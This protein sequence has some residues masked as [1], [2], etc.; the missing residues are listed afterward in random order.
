[1]NAS[2]PIPESFSDEESA[3][4]H[5]DEDPGLCRPQA[6]DLDPRA[7]PSGLDYVKS[8]IKEVRAIHKSDVRDEERKTQT[9]SCVY[10]A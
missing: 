5:L 6:L 8:Y 10:E 4:D 9:L 7:F 3:P 1:M 2:L